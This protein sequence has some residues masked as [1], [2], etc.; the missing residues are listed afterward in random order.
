[1]LELLDW[2]EKTAWAVEIRQSLWLYP[3]LEIVHILGIVMLVGP[4]FMFDLRLLGF[5]KNIPFASLAAH[6]LPWSRRS[7]LLI[8]PSGALLFI[9]NANALGVDPTFWTKMSLIGV[10][11]INVFVFHRFIFTS[12]LNPDGDL[13]FQA[14]I[15]GCVSIVVW[16]AVIACGRLLAY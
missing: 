2:L 16:I 8:I 10:A 11:A 5:S 12:N 3:A 4:A 7:L 15:S 9:T 1:M 6:L 13:P 14:R